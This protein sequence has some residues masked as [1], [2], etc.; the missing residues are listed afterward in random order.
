MELTRPSRN[1]RRARDRGPAPV[2][3]PARPSGGTWADS[4]HELLSLQGR[5]HT[6][7]RCFRGRTT[8]LEDSFIPK[9]KREE[10]NA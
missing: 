5:R 2:L 6:R 1:G 10:V 9:A 4:R 7:S 8:S 3:C